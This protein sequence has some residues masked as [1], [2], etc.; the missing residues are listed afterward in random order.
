MTDESESAVERRLWFLQV[1]LE[2]MDVEKALALAARMEAFINAGEQATA[3]KD[4]LRHVSSRNSPRHLLDGSIVRR[5][6]RSAPE[7]SP[8]AASA[9]DVPGRLLNDAELYAFR[10][11]AVQ[12]A[13]NYDLASRFGLTPRQANAIRM[14][15][16]KGT[17]QVALSVAARSRG[18]LVD[19][20]S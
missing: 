12:G 2:K 13:S 20:D 10:D 11:R 1:L 15:L 9:R 6:D 8:S 3:P 19:R 7:R 14:G 17:P 16:A 4:E 18:W 5:D